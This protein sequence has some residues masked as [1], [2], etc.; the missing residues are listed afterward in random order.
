MTKLPIHLFI[1]GTVLLPILPSSAADSLPPLGRLFMSP[2]QRAALDRQRQLNIREARSLEDSTMR[3]DGVVLRSAGKSTVWI[4]NQPQ[5]ENGSETGVAAALTRQRPERA[6]LSTGTD[7]PADLK[8]GVSINRTTRETT[9]G[10]A[11]GEIRVERT[12]P[13]K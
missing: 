12:R 1:L 11:A 7:A 9:G 6:I 13:G 5:T 4:N 2:E 10:L 3:L 8:V